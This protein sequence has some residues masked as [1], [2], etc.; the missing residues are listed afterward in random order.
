MSLASSQAVGRYEQ[1]GTDA[2]L[3]STNN[4]D[5]KPVRP[6]RAR[7]GARFQACAPFEPAGEGTRAAQDMVISPGSV[8]STQEVGHTLFDERLASETLGPPSNRPAER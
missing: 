3:R 7:H 5:A 1:V 6:D 2:G 8:L 4:P